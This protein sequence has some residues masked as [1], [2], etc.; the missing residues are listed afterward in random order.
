MAVTDQTILEQIQR[1]TL[2]G[3][4]DLG[5]TWPSGMWTLAEVLGYLNQRQNRFLAATG[6]FWTRAE[7]AVVAGQTAQ[8]A[9]ANWVATVFVAFKKGGVY[10]ELPKL[11]TVEL[12]LALP[13]WPGASSASPK[14]YY[15]TDG[16]TLTTYVVPAPTAAVTDLE[17][18]YVAL[19]TA[20]TQ[21][22][23][24]NFSVSDEFVP[25]IKYGALADMFA[26]IGPAHNP[27]LAQACEE[28]WGEGLAM[29]ALMAQE[30]WFAL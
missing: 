19:G 30:G 21:N 29:G 11:D 7:T 24:V 1:V 15:E 5:A 3:A 17:R 23:A 16:A 20:L 18:Y 22:P 28:R 10:R 6:L 13:T 12:D 8:A 4:G 2:E 9:P 14:G 25:T 27:V 26:K